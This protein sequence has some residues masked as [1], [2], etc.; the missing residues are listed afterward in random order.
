[1]IFCIN[2]GIHFIAL[3]KKKLTKWHAEKADALNTICSRRLYEGA[4]RIMAGILAVCLVVALMPPMAVK[5]D[6]A[7]K[8]PAGKM[9]FRIYWETTNPT[10]NLVNAAAC[11]KTSLSNRNSESY[12]EFDTKFVGEEKG[13]FTKEILTNKGIYY[14]KSIDLPLGK[15]YIG[16]LQFDITSKLGGMRKFAGIIH[17][18]LK[19]MM[20]GEYEEVAALETGNI[21]G[22]TDSIFSKSRYIGDFSIYGEVYGYGK[23]GKMRSDTYM[24]HTPMLKDGVFESGITTVYPNT[25]YTPLLSPEKSLMT[26]WG[27]RWIGEDSVDATGF[28]PT[29][30]HMG[31]V[32]YENPRIVTMGADGTI[33]PAS[34][35]GVSVEENATNVFTL[36]I[37]DAMNTNFRVA[38]DVVSDRYGTKTT[39]VSN[40][41]TVALPQANT[42]APPT[43]AT[44]IKSR[45][46][47]IETVEGQNYLCTTTN[48]TPSVSASGW[49]LAT[50]TT[51]TFDSLAPGQD[52]YFWTYV[53]KSAT[54]EASNVSSPLAV[55]TT[56]PIGE[57]E[58]T[59][60]EPSAGVSLPRITQFGVPNNA[61][62]E[63]TSISWKYYTKRGQWETIK[64]SMFQFDSRHQ[65]TMAVDLPSDSDYEFSANPIVTV[66]GKSASVS[67]TSDRKLNVT[68]EFATPTKGKPR[69]TVTLKK[70]GQPWTNSGAKVGLTSSQFV[71]RHPASEQDK[72]GVFVT[73]NTYE[74][75]T[76]VRIEVQQQDQSFVDTGLT[77][78]V[79]WGE[80]EPN[81]EVDFVTVNFHDDK[82]E[83][84]TSGQDTIQYV[85]SGKSPT[86]PRN[87]GLVPPQ[88]DQILGW[89]T[90]ES[91]GEKLVD[92][93]FAVGADP[94]FEKTDIYARWTA[95]ITEA[96]V[97]GV[98]APVAAAEAVTET[99][100]S[101]P[102]G[103]NYEIW[104][105]TWSPELVDGKFDYNTEYT[106][107]VTLLA[108]DLNSFSTKMKAVMNGKTAQIEEN[109][110]VT[111]TVSYKFPVTGT[112]PAL[113]LA[114]AKKAVE[115]MNV[116][117]SQEAVAVSGGSVGSYLVRTGIK[118]FI[119][120][121]LSDGNTGVSV[122]D[123]TDVE[124]LN[125]STQPAAGTEEQPDGTDGKFTYNVTLTKGTQTL[126][127]ENLSGIITATPYVGADVTEAPAFTVGGYIYTKQSASDDSAELKLIKEG[128][129]GTLYYVYDAETGGNSVAVSVKS[130][131][132]V[133]T[134]AGDAIKEVQEI[135]D[136]YISAKSGEKAE[137]SRV[138]ITIKP[139]EKEQTSALEFVSG[140]DR[141]GKPQADSD[142]ATFILSAARP[143]KTAYQVYSAATGEEQPAGVTASGIG[144][145]VTLTGISALEENTV[146]YLTAT[147]PEKKESQRASITVLAYVAPSVTIGADNRVTAFVPSGG[148]EKLVT[149]TI[150]LN[151]DKGTNP[152][153]E[154]QLSDFTAGT[155]STLQQEI[156]LIAIDVE[157]GTMTVGAK[158]YEPSSLFDLYYKGE[159][160]GR[161]WLHINQGTSTDATLKKLELSTGT[162]DQE[163][164][165]DRAAY[166]VSVD[167]E[168]DSITVT[169]TANE[170]RAK[171]KVNEV[172]VNSGEK[173]EPIELSVGVNNI[174]VE[175]TAP[176]GKTIKNYTVSV[177]RENP[178]TSQPQF[179]AGG[180]VYSKKSLVDDT[181][182]FTLTKA[183]GK[184]VYRVYNQKTGETESELITAKADGAVLTLTGI[185]SLVEETDFYISAKEEGSSESA[186]TKVTVRPYD[187]PADTP[188]FVSNKVSFENPGAITVHFLM[189]NHVQGRDYQLYQTMTD[190]NPLEK[191]IISV[192]G[193][194]LVLTYETAPTS[195]VTY[196]VGAK[197]SGKPDSGRTEIRVKPY[198]APEASTPLAF[199]AGGNSFRKPRNDSSTATFT[200]S[201]TPVSG[202]QYQVYDAFTGGSPVADV[203][204]SVS[205]KTL[206]LAGTA[207][208]SITEDTT[209]YIGVTESGRTE[210]SRGA[211][212]IYAYKEP[213]A[214]PMFTVSSYAKTSAEDETATY[215]LKTAPGNTIYKVYGQAVGGAEANGLAAAANGVTLTL[216]GIR[217]II[218]KTTYY[219]SATEDG[220]G[221]S[222]SRTAVT[223]EPY[224]A[225]SITMGTDTTVSVTYLSTDADT[226]EASDTITAL[227]DQGSDSRYT[228]ETS[229]FMI[230]SSD[231]QKAAIDGVTVTKASAD[232]LT[233][234]VQKGITAAGGYLWYQ[235]QLVSAVTIQKTVQTPTE[236]RIMIGTYENG[237]VTANVSAAVAGTQVE[238]T[239]HPNS[240]YELDVIAVKKS[241]STESVSLTGNDDKRTFTM[242]EYDV[243]V[244]T[245]FKL[246][247]D[248]GAVNTAKSVVE[249][250]TY[251]VKQADANAIAAVK[252]WLVGEI[253][254][255]LAKGETG[256]SVVSAD[257][258]MDSSFTA[259]QAGTASAVNGTNG[260]FAFTVKLK[261]NGALAATD[262][263][264]GT[265]TA[266]AYV[267]PV[268]SKA[269]EFSQSTYTKASA[270]ENTAE[271][272]LTAAAAAATEFAV[273][274]QEQ[275]GKSL[276]G[277]SAGAEGTKL[278]LTG[279]SGVVEET[280]YYISATEQGKTES[281]RTKVTIKP[282]T[283]PKS[284]AKQIIGF[285][286]S[287]QVGESTIDEQSHTVAVTMPYGA[288]LTRLSPIVTIS[289][290]A[291]VSPA[292]GVEKDFSSPVV[293]TVTAENLSMQEYTVTVTLEDV[294][295]EYDV[296]YDVTNITANDQPTKIELGEKLEVTLVADSGY[297]LPDSITVKMGGDTLE[298]FDFGYEKSTGKVTI[299]QV[300]GD[301]KIIASG[302]QETQKSSNAN[303][304]S[305]SYQIG[306]GT[307]TVLDGFAEGTI[308]YDV[309]LPYE[310]SQTAEIT[311][312][313]T[314]S[315][316]EANITENNGVIL[317]AGEG[318]ATITVTAEDG[319]TTKTYALKFTIASAPVEYVVVTDIIGGPSAAMVGK[320]LQ[321]SGTV[322]PANATNQEIT[323]EIIRDDGT[324]SE[325]D[326]DNKITP[327][328]AGKVT[329]KAT[330][331]DGLG[332]GQDYTKEFEITV[333]GTATPSDAEYVA[334]ASNAVRNGNYQVDQSVTEDDSNFI[335]EL[336]S[337]INKILDKLLGNDVDRIEDRDIRNLT[338]TVTPAKGDEDDRNGQD[339]KFTF[340]V[341]IHKGEESITV[342]GL[343]G[344][345]KATPFTNEEQREKDQE[346]VDEAIAAIED[347]D[348]I[349]AQ[350]SA[351][352]QA[353]L[354]S[355]L[356]TKLKKKV[357]NASVTGIQFVCDIEFAIAGTKDKPEGVNGTFTFRASVSKGIVKNQWTAEL[358]GTIMAE[359]YVLKSPKITTTS[360]PDGISGEEYHA[361][362]QGESDTDIVW[363]HIEGILPAGTE[364]KPDGNLSGTPKETGRFTFVVQAENGSEQG[365]SVKELSVTINAPSEQEAYT[366]T[367]K[368]GTG[369]IISPSGEIIVEKGGKQAFTITPAKRYYTSDVLVD[370]ISVGRQKTY[371]FENVTGNHTIEAVF[372]RGS[373]GPSGNSSSS[374][375]SSSDKGSSSAASTG[376]KVITTALNTTTTEGGG[377]ITTSQTTD[378]A[379]GQ[380]ITT[381]VEKDPTGNVIGAN[382]FVSASQIT[383]SVGD[384]KAQISASINDSLVS[385]AI[386]AA[387]V[388]IPVNVTVT[389]PKQDVLA[390]LGN[391]TVS[392][393]NVDL[394]I[395]SQIVTGGKATITGVTLEQ[396]VV[397]AAKASGKDITVTV[398]D[399]KGNF[400]YE[401]QID[402]AALQGSAS[403]TSSMNLAVEVKPVQGLT[404]SDEEIKKAAGGNEGLYVGVNHNG[405]LLATL[406]VKIAS[407]E[408][409]GLQPGAEVFL[410]QYNPATKQLE[411]ADNNRYTVAA[412]KTVTIPMNQGGEYVLLPAE[413]PLA[414]AGVVH[415][416]KKGEYPYLI[417]RQYGCR[418]EDLIA[419]NHITDVRNLQI[420]QQLI[421]PAK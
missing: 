186:R 306:E 390:Q 350:K 284:S 392:N 388:T 337:L 205:N 15:Y 389:L 182:T 315:H 170:S 184:E 253:N 421:I 243:T 226:T 122:A 310:T 370:G 234:T 52:Y 359:K 376:N 146:Y 332:A 197:E 98:T 304:A 393:I 63:V 107:K 117:L 179:I 297:T 260:S 152:D 49:K 387:G 70:D 271:F 264:D 143:E 95:Q 372:K 116:T 167:N 360:L 176:D 327:K 121:Q 291:S 412:D 39:A 403:E 217:N 203:A 31:A 286:I 138:K 185:S 42:P 343:T 150:D 103:S 130:S 270:D 230:S 295:T 269:P 406:H 92:V 190:T 102:D 140:K 329:V 106:A 61:K 282:Y 292:S 415:T 68:Y 5:A 335:A 25:S 285:S 55:A 248:Q 275:G 279:I 183:A 394:M 166:T 296:T 113:D 283:A 235:D 64:D 79:I 215:T 323:W 32:H 35:H 374:N 207:V 155:S 219:I 13:Y 160:I 178:P 383:T 144:N 358:D 191:P 209:W 365:V 342:E 40:E 99:D 419:V 162:L 228:F 59:V 302:V 72:S 158:K 38:F 380:T 363:T 201:A 80:P 147:E 371:I 165:Q 362:L 272:T 311:L 18:Q 90:K 212:T 57:V 110:G 254:T 67:R 250:H 396:D 202:T 188:E 196:Y 239:I 340:D 7:A 204:V 357:G 60:P 153:Y 93:P 224:V 51:M 108:S 287:G 12:W 114:E 50:G 28:S 200:L 289:E 14:Y 123:Y 20:T 238:L 408:G 348:Y 145:T 37:T 124:K 220:K 398:K 227:L 252:T 211:V 397:A 30:Y 312:K 218:S 249:G 195:G 44:S 189:K 277:I 257:I 164:N 206:T 324:G 410:Y 267:P 62:Y 83:L 328:S 174:K 237:S 319:I 411:I 307:T 298:N 54:A 127:M 367:A 216:T 111:T 2:K 91:D 221:E 180:N 366:I 258:T 89:V 133:L 301:V 225:P 41:I 85:I 373:I 256:V 386:D 45:S 418:V 404:G 290:K 344:T 399:E 36:K 405:T 345:I 172:S 330:I 245:S 173:S 346:T 409:A 336:V 78:E 135:T 23:A 305:L 4:R 378:P 369:G 109:T 128:E 288:E 132:K 232:S 105:L 299:L 87:T 159:R 325:L 34:L 356:R 334:S 353:K 268:Q 338:I 317:E 82:D 395:P 136:F 1:M 100:L 69:I 131:G 118:A 156:Y 223:I 273:Y 246:T 236:Y 352:T 339:G 194:D 46:I 157:N 73:S 391:E 420:G 115:G 300:T 192:D 151:F 163:F 48:S 137:S 401:W 43:Q 416:V 120:L 74:S 139:A 22:D 129:S 266:T 313:G 112:D 261:K 265:I 347:A 210:S 66:N 384:G 276:D 255:L 314:T 247:A 142:T 213:S 97:L 331:A 316:S 240:G 413:I 321:L 229:D 58:L 96:E 65:V 375:D 242:P 308:S 181:A 56:A 294:P 351:L 6:T 341:D 104:G 27:Y 244:E 193:N 326:L 318:T 385:Q 198:V 9:Q 175:V 214:T 24:E 281:T 368:A 29:F 88:A 354:E 377:Q 171:I 3:I 241:G 355:A 169:P 417:A 53:P 251:T 126:K 280:D 381:T 199:A 84:L 414:G 168:I 322:K 274:V 177:T 21:W 94:V 231:S 400:A 11:E 148:V 134:V 187:A 81:I 71:G 233:V 10:G 47:T 278:T 361:Q 262:K 149:D 402:G 33:T 379:T 141:F 222:A 19:N 364:L 333:E 77:A 17:I 303:L 86:E 75:N 16:E 309:E 259:A 161:P 407:L 208:G 101:V 8:L 76:S 293:Y 119:N 26:T 382:A 125:V 320:T 263:V 154:F 349:I